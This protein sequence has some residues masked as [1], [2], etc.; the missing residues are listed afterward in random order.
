MLKKAIRIGLILPSLLMGQSILDSYVQYGLENNLALRQHNFSYKRSVAALNEARGMFL[1]SVSIEARYTRAGGGRVIDFPVGDLMNPVYESLNQLLGIPAFPTDLPNEHILFLRE[2]EQETK[3][4]LVQPIFQPGILYNYRIQRDL[5][6][7]QAYSRDVYT[8]QLIADIKTAYFNYLKTNRIVLLLTE[9]ER[10]LDENVRVSQSLFKNNMATQDV[11]FRAE[12]EFYGFKQQQAEAEKGRDLS[13]SYFN[14]LLNRPLDSAIEIVPDSELVFSW[15]AQLESDQEC[16]LQRREELRQIEKTISIMKNK[17]GLSCSKFLPGIT[18]VADYGYQGEIYRFGPEDD[19]WMAS[20]IGSWNLFN[21]FQD[22]FKIDQA[23]LEEKEMENQLETVQQQIRLQVREAHHNLN[24][25][26]KSIEAALARERS[27]C[28]SFA[29]IGKQY[30]EGMV[31][32]ITFI[33][34]RNTKT[35]AEVNAVVTRYE[36]WIKLAEWEKITAAYDL[37]RAINNI[38]N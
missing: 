35:Q 11:V 23:K 13:A 26:I 6:E 24:L 18:A 29:I 1:P 32:Q 20:L 15:T 21:G 28:K 37:D 17:K 10:L 4:R 3:L 14:F 22:R 16:A 31:P 5:K 34:A 2:E 36:Y 19:Y 8:R 7:I 9:T 30:R 38:N 25:A 27:A 12:A 33:D